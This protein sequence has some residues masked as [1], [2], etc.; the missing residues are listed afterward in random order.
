MDFH[1]AFI[2]GCFMRSWIDFSFSYVRP[3]H[4][5][6]N[7]KKNQFSFPTQTMPAKRNVLLMLQPFC[8]QCVRLYVH[9]MERWKAFFLIIFIRTIRRAKGMND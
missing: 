3:D 5:E 4:K 8:F 6:V 2:V 7:T 9:A 1:E